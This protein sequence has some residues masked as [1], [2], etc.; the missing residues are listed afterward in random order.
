MLIHIHTI[1]LEWLL[2]RVV[3]LHKDVLPTACGPGNRYGMYMSCDILGALSCTVISKLHAQ[4]HLTIHHSVYSTDTSSTLL[5][6]KNSS[7]SISMRFS[8]AVN[9]TGERYGE[10]PGA[11]SLPQNV[12]ATRDIVKELAY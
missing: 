1:F 4:V 9:S 5:D 10:R 2:Q 3:L 8:V 12:L 7:E 11:S 6:E